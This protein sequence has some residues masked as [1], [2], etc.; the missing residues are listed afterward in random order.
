MSPRAGR[1]WWKDDPV[2]LPSLL[3][4]A[5]LE[6]FG[7]QLLAVC[8]SVTDD[9]WGQTAH[10]SRDESRASRITRGNVRLTS[11][12]RDAAQSGTFEDLRN[13]VGNSSS[14]NRCVS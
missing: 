11:D 4:N 6:C 14:L 8:D 3:G 5:P 2:R 9:Q 1:G 12:S 10:D 7:I 13:A